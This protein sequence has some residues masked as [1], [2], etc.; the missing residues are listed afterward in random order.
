[1][2]HRRV[3][4]IHLYGLLYKFDT[5]IRLNLRERITILHGP[6]GCG[7]T[8][9]LA[10]IAAIFK[11]DFSTVRQIPFRVI[12]IFF[13]DETELRVFS[14]FRQL[15]WNYHETP[16]YEA[17]LPLGDLG[18]TGDDRGLYFDVVDPGDQHHVFVL[19]PDGWHSLV[20][21]EV[22]DRAEIERL[23]YQIDRETTDISFLNLEPRPIKEQY[24]L[25]ELAD[26]SR[27]A[28]LRALFGDDT[29]PSKLDHVLQ[30]V[31]IYSLGTDR[32]T[33]ITMGLFTMTGAEHR[34]ATT[35]ID[36]LEGLISVYEEKAWEDTRRFKENFTESYHHTMRVLDEEPVPSVHDSLSRLIGHEEWWQKHALYGWAPPFGADMESQA[37]FYDI[38]QSFEKEVA[39]RGATP[40]EEQ[41]IL[42]LVVSH[43]EAM[44]TRINWVAE[45]LSRFLHILQDLTGKV[46]IIGSDHY[47]IF[48]PRANVDTIKPVTLSSGEQHIL[49]LIGSLLFTKFMGTPAY[50]LVL[51]DEPELSL[52][53]SWQRQFLQ[54]LEEI[55]ALEPMDV[56]IATHSPQIVYD[57]RDL[58]V[59][60]GPVE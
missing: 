32:L 29:I 41:V 34:S 33:K 59:S 51:I 53:V 26:N 27:G 8:S 10:L 57:R 19:Q 5:R 23:K 48:D 43:I 11:K 17:I 6:N 18:T 56:I 45:R 21:P 58:M 46:F 47:I 2:T 14:T 35:L 38:V 3:T 54:I 7:K 31:P 24:R 55:I 49:V 1:M 36:D 42:H 52:H 13:D 40:E 44:T 37:P 25:L 60:L 16:A 28:R 22:P 50:P 39:P 9:I 12:R 30:E 20:P 15:A 4:E